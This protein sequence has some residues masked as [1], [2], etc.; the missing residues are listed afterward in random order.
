[1][2]FIPTSATLLVE[3][4]H[5]IFDIIKVYLQGYNTSTGAPAT[6]ST[7]NDAKTCFIRNLSFDATEGDILEALKDYGAYAV[8]V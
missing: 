7:G 6:H 4:I 3:S 2:R 8:R 1:M 5:T